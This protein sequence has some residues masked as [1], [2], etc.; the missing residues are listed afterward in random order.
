RAQRGL[1]PSVG[2]ARARARR[3]RAVGGGARAR[4]GQQRLAREAS[5]RCGQAP[6]PARS[7]PERE[8]L[9]Q[10]AHTMPARGQATPATRAARPEGV[11]QLLQRG[12][13]PGAGPSERRPGSSAWGGGE[14]T[15]G[16]RTR[17]LSRL[18]PWRSSPRFGERLR[19]L[20]Q[21]GPSTPRMTKALAPAGGPPPPTR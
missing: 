16:S 8:A 19:P 11:R 1:W 4:L 20:A 21:A 18:A 17:P 15:A 13:V 5:E 6:P 7:A 9:A 3:P 14:T 12:V 10:R 2:P